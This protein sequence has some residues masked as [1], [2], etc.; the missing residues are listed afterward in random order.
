MK[1]SVLSLENELII[2]IREA[3]NKIV[4]SGWAIY[5][6]DKIYSVLHTIKT[7]RAGSNIKTPDKY[8]YPK[9][10]LIN[11]SNEDNE[12]FRHCTAYHQTKREQIMIY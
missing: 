12:C 7:P 6:F 4:G 1:E 10:G 9:C 5:R 3:F 11:I 8:N 2:K